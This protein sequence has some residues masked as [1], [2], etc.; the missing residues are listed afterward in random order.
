MIK[1]SQSPKLAFD[2][3]DQR[4]EEKETSNKTDNTAEHNLTEQ[5]ETD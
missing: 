2:I 1:Y 3:L 4:D 5:N